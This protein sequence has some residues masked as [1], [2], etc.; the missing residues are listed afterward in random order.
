[1]SQIDFQDSLKEDVPPIV[2]TSEPHMACLFL[3]D[4]SGSMGA[5]KSVDGERS[6]PYGN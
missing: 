1:M 5:S 3:V 6:F 2:N 4:T